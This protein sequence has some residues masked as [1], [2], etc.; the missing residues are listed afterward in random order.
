VNLNTRLNR[1]LL[2]KE[3]M[4]LDL[5][6][7]AFNALNHRNN[8]VPNATFGTAPFPPGAPFTGAPTAVADPRS[9]QLAARLSF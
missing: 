6:A 5:S 2:L 9:I 1:T 4:R 8:E 3:S 7:E